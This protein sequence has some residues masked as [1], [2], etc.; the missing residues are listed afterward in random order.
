M[1]APPY[2]SSTVMPST[3]RSPNLRHR[4]AGN[5]LSRSI[6]GGAR[7]DLVGGKGLDRGTQHVGRLAEVEVEAGQ[8]IWPRTPSGQPLPGSI[9]WITS[10]PSNSGWP[11]YR[12]RFCP[13]SL[14]ARR[15][16]SD[17]VH[18]S[19]SSLLAPDRV[20]R[21]QH[22]VV[23]FGSAQQVECDEA[24]DTRQ[25]SCHA[26]SRLLRNPLLIRVRPENGSSR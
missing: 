23:V 26:W 18:A 15:N 19:K 22:V 12:P 5:A 16:A 2:S 14:C 17:R 9:V 25:M 11:R 4:S 7:R 24:W 13:A 20:R 6:V 10:K 3:P 1:P 21:I 8:A